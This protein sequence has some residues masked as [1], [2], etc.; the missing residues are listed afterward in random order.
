[1]LLVVLLQL[2]SSKIKMAAGGHLHFD[3]NHNVT[4]IK[5]YPE[6]NVAGLTNKFNDQGFDHELCKNVDNYA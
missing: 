3:N 1:M 6:Q 4:R 5:S 2:N